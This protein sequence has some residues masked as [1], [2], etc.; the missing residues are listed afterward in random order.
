VIPPS[1]SQPLALMTKVPH[2][3]GRPR[4]PRRVGSP[5]ALRWAA[6]VP[7]DLDV[8]DDDEALGDELVDVGQE[9][10][11][12]LNGVDDDHRNGRVVGQREDASGVDRVRGAVARRSPKDAG[13]GQTGLVGDTQGLCVIT[14][15]RSES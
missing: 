1:S 2:G 13:A 10:P 3:K 12:A 6:E 9:R 7:D 4:Q 5:L 8:V 14:P 11:D 15:S